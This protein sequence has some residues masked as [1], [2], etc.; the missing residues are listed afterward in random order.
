MEGE[1][2]LKEMSKPLFSGEEKVEEDNEVLEAGLGLAAAG[3]SSSVTFD[4]SAVS[5][6]HFTAVSAVSNES[7]ASR[8]RLSTSMPANHHISFVDRSANWPRSLSER[9][10]NDHMIQLIQQRRK[11]M[12]SIFPSEG[13][14]EVEDRQSMELHSDFVQHLKKF[15][16]SLG[17]QFKTDMPSMEIRLQNLSYKVPSFTDGG[18]S[19]KIQ[20]I[21]NSSPVYKAKKFFQRLVKPKNETEMNQKKVTNV[22]TN[23]NLTLKP[24]CMYLV[25]GPPLSGKT[26]LLKAIAGML[27]QGDFPSGYSETKHITGQILYNNLVCSGD[28]ASTDETQRTLIKNLVA[29]VRQNDAHAPRLTVAETFLFSGNCKDGSI[30]ASKKGVDKDGKVGLTLEGLGLSHVQDTFVG[31]EQIRGVSGGQRRR[32]TLGE[33]ITFDTPLLCG[34][35]ISTGLDTA[36]TVDIL[37]IISYVSR[38]L[39]RIS[40]VSLLQP[41]PETVAMFDEIILLSDGGNVI[42]TGPTEVSCSST[43]SNF[44]LVQCTN[45]HIHLF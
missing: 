14:M 21:Y 43:P 40:V 38:L 42:Y 33:M 16:D 15:L 31:N 17:D 39:S 45:L 26:S 35:E 30:R 19:G 11:S 12:A 13:E 44:I 9:P 3:E 29:F 28:G 34:D 7:T 27:P 6:V 22:L 5:G 25:L 36:S 4:P 32:V 18:G 2:T 10:R 1:N 41:S 23:V 20:T 8:S 24:K 37:R